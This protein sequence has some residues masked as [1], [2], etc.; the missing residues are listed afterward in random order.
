MRGRGGY[1]LVELVVASAVTVVV[2][3]QIFFVV[4]GL[5]RLISASYAQ[6]DLA[7]AAHEM[8]ERLYHRLTPDPE[9]YAPG[10]AS[11][12]VAYVDSV[13]MGLSGFCFA[14]SSFDVVGV[15]RRLMWNDGKVVVDNVPSTYSWLTPTRLDGDWDSFAGASGTDGLEFR[16]EMSK[17]GATV[18]GTNTL[19]AF[20][21]TGI[22]L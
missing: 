15:T 2:M 13:A 16:V 20:P 18:A 9:V 21:P 17:N 7:L 10:A 1:T 6:C 14:N 3:A 12:E 8:R 5:R 22:P 19:P 4:L 11:L